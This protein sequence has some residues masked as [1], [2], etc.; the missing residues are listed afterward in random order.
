MGRSPFLFLSSP[1]TRQDEPLNT[2]SFSS[3]SSTCLILD[4]ELFSFLLL[5]LSFSR[6]SFA[7]FLEIAGMFH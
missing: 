1:G 5:L 2:N 4:I 3:F 6:I 7:S